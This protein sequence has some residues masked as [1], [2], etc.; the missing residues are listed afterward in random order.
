MHIH[1]LGLF[2]DTF[3]TYFSQS[4]LGKARAKGLVTFHYHQLRDWSHNKHHAVD[5]KPYGGG[6]GMVIMADVVCAAVL[7]LKKDHQISR[8]VLPSP[9]GSPLIPAVAQRLSCEDSLLFVCGRYEGVDQRAIDKVVDEEIS[10]G[11][12]VISGGELAACVITDAVCRY[13][14]GIVGKADSVEND[15]YQQGLLEHPHYTRPEIFEGVPVPQVLI[16]GNHAEIKKWRKNESIKRTLERRPDLID[17]IKGAKPM[18]NNQ[19][20]TK[21]ANNN[22]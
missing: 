20:T 11:D 6:S 5:D 14:P 2:P 1:I 8:V 3:D 7:A 9:A 21:K 16:N 10:I 4:L 15:S 12:Y 18:S 17:R 13:I 19:G 22:G